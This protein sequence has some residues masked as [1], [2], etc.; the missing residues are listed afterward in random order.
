MFSCD[1]CKITHQ[2]ILNKR[3]FL[4]SLHIYNQPSCF[5]SIAQSLRGIV[6]Q[7]K[8]QRTSRSRSCFSERRR[9][10]WTNRVYIRTRRLHVRHEY[11]WQKKHPRSAV[12]LMFLRVQIVREMMNVVAAIKSRA[13]VTITSKLFW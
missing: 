9:Q 6:P 1:I 12:V 2:V 5:L 13:V 8:W 11:N 10:Y 3:C 7:S 4:R